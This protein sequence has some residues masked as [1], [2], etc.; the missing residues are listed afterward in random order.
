MRELLLLCS[1]LA[2]SACLRTTE[3]RCSGD[4]SCSGGG[5]CEAT[6]YCSFVDPDCSSGRR[7]TDS[8]GS[9]AGTCTSGGGG[10][11]DADVTPTD[12]ATDTVTDG[13]TTDTPVTAGCP[14]GYVTVAGAEA[15][16]LYRVLTAPDDFDAQEAACQLTTAKAHL[17]APADLAELTA[18]DTLVGAT[19]YWTGI[20]DKATQGTYVNTF[21]M[22]QTYLPWA[23]GNPSSQAMDQCSYAL[24]VLH[25]IAEDRCNTNLPAV[26]ECVP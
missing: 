5:I 1:V 19:P 4:T 6:G 26:C 24:S 18:I 21:G 2:T 13:S 11:D 14:A 9:L 22:A 15:G 3:Y 23:A 20:N 7:Y 8:A 16:H 17:F 10:S 12:T 25:Q